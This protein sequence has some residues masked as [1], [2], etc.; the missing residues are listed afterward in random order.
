MGRHKEPIRD[1]LKAR[2]EINFLFADLSLESP[3]GGM[4][5]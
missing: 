2:G 5:G 3:L 1:I 4:S